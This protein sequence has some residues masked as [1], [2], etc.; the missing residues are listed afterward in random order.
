MQEL[1]AQTRDLMPQLGESLHPLYVRFF[2]DK[3]VASFVPR[4]IGN[5]YRCRRIGEVGAQQMQLDVGTLKQT[6]LDLPTLG[7]ANA[8][9]AYT[10]LVA[11]E[12]HK[13]EQLLKLVQTPEE[14][15]E[16]TVEE[17]SK[18]KDAG[19]IDLQRILELKGLKK[20]EM[21][22][23]LDNMK[24]AMSTATESSKKLK[25]MLNLGGS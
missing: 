13:A 7:Q 12:V 11:S 5:I 4:L 21:D 17:M 20:A 18:E 10:K 22:R 15:L 2:C 19:V 8:T 25:K 24:D 6:L 14:L 16:T 3:F 9:N 23:M 1:V